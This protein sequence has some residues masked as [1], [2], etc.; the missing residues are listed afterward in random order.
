MQITS[1]KGSNTQP[2]IP[3][4]DQFRTSFHTQSSFLIVS[5]SLT[6]SLSF[7]SLALSFACIL[8]SLPF[9]SPLLFRRSL[10]RRSTRRSCAIPTE[11][12]L[13]RDSVLL[14]SCEPRLWHTGRSEQ[15][16]RGVRTL[17]RLLE[18]PTS[19]F[20]KII[21][22]LEKKFTRPLRINRSN[23]WLACTNTTN[24]CRAKRLFLVTPRQAL[25]L[26]HATR[27]FSFWFQ[28]LSFNEYV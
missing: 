28:N 12:V 23:D 2:L 17:L 6:H 24:Q 21:R 19:K 20:S 22:W 16:A 26:A 3:A 15:S 18:N 13:R 25:C 5:L 27:A 11:T 10:A 4:H 7:P 9:Q 1:I 14:T 8:S